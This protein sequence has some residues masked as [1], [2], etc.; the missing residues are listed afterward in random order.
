LSGAVIPTSIS[1][2]GMGIAF[3]KYMVRISR[4][5]RKQKMMTEINVEE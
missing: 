2:G 5:G 1:S 3:I 4:D